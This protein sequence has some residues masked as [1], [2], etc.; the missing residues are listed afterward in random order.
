MFHY[1][2]AKLAAV[3]WGNLKMHF[4]EEKGGVPENT[5]YNIMR[6]P[7]EGDAH[8]STASMFAHVIPF[9]RFVRSHMA[10]KRKFPDRVLKP[11]EGRAE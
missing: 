4:G 2:G 11:K 1:S 5:L 3:R 9:Q 6:D 10:I 8:Q 7:R